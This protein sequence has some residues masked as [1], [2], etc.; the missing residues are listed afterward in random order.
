MFPTVASFAPCNDDGRRCQQPTAFSY[1]RS[2]RSLAGFSLLVVSMSELDSSIFVAVVVAGTSI[3]VWPCCNSL[4]CG[5]CLLTE[6]PDSPISFKEEAKDSNAAD[7]CKEMGD[8]VSCSAL[9]KLLSTHLSSSSTIANP[10]LLAEFEDVSMHRH[11]LTSS[12]RLLFV[13][14][15]DLFIS[16]TF[17]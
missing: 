16:A 3:V 10:K 2:K 9:Q 11:C 6:A 17:R 7:I 15:I 5:G 4:F 1:L 8:M 12:P 13:K 14:S